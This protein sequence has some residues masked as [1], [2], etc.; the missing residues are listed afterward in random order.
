M[1]GHQ[2]IDA[3]LA[4]LAGRLPADTVDE[5]ADG[6]TETWHHHLD[7]G[8]TAERAAHAAIAEFGAA[9]RIAD[10]FVARAP[11][12]R[13]ARLLL[14]TGPVLG[15][16]WGTS[17]VATRVWTWPIPPAVGAAYVVALLAT[18]AL[19]IGAATSRY[20]Y[21]RTRLGGI[22]ALT[23]VLLDAAMIAAVAVLA[24]T[25]VWPMGIAVAASLARIGLAVPRLPMALTA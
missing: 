4:G 10:E 25:L 9:T 24:P 13:T 8:L 3:Y 17:L 12:R 14:A 6:L 21:R 23:L 5:L 15:V 22:G 7:R 18:V 19:L 11:G 20:S 1:A 16:C 2:L